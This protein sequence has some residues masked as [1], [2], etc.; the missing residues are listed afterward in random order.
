MN[1]VKLIH[2]SP[3]NTV[4]IW[5][6]CQDY[7]MGILFSPSTLC[8]FKFSHRFIWSIRDNQYVTTKRAKFSIY[9]ISDAPNVRFHLVFMQ[10]C[11]GMKSGTEMSEEGIWHSSSYIEN[12]FQ[13]LSNWGIFTFLDL[14]TL[15]TYMLKKITNIDQKAQTNYIGYVVVSIKSIIPAKITISTSDSLDIDNT[16]IE[17][18]TVTAIPVTKFRGWHQILR[19]YVSFVLLMRIRI[20]IEI[21]FLDTVYLPIYIILLF[22][23]WG[24]RIEQRCLYT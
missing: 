7:I 4:Q 8:F 19:L 6:I 20:C 1:Q 5:R 16:Y 18:P 3:S 12:S 2:I 15:E 21:I 22:V 9:P 23:I 17:T 14:P 24:F 10:V 13:F 11:I